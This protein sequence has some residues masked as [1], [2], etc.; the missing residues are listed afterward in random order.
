MPSIINAA[1]SGGLISTADTSGVL[2]LQ[3]ASTTALTINASQQV[4]VGTGSPAYALDV[5][6][7]AAPAI[8]LSRSGTAGQI[9][10]MVFEDGNATL[11][12]GSTTRVASDSGA[13]S[14]STGGTSGAVT[15]GTERMR[16]T[17]GGYVKIANDPNDIYGPSGSYH[18]IVSDSAGSNALR[19][20]QNNASFND[21]IL[22]VASNRNTTNT[23]YYFI[24][25][26]DSAFATKFSVAD[27]GSVGT[28]GSVALGGTLIPTSGVGIRFPATQSASSDANTLDDYEEGTFSISYS[29][30]GSSP[31]IVSQS[32]QYVKIGKSVTVSISAQINL[33]STS[34]TLGTLSGFPF[35]FVTNYVVANGRE[36][37]ST[38]NSLQ[39]IGQI[40]STDAGLSFYNNS[41][42]LSGITFLGIGITFSY[43]TS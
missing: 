8:R 37:Y 17:S 34:T 25:C 16:I 31:T 4:G 26:I 7:T 9:A 21:T 27:S 30:G 39:V 12:S 29:G 15:G 38:G 13:M 20:L 3:T 2:Q 1:T 40:S 35:P 24:D 23:S 6:S 36:W 14:F 41:A 22:R 18:E 19:V 28:A 10:S 42:S 11:G 43:V 5:R 33:G 32:N